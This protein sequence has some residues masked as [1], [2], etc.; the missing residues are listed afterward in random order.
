MR[1]DNRAFIVLEQSNDLTGKTIALLK[2][3]TGRYS[4]AFGYDD[5]NGTW[6]YEHE[7]KSKNA[8][9]YAANEFKNLIEGR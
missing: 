3:D 8:F 6:S 2:K 7:N 4:V 1:K 5:N 9:F